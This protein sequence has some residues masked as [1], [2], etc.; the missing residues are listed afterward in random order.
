MKLIYAASGGAGE[1]RQKKTT[2][3]TT[4]QTTP[5]KK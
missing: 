4:P 1:Q 2:P 5:K 3:Q